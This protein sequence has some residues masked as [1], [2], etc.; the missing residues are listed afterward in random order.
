MTRQ[1]PAHPL[2]D[3][4]FYHPRYWPTWLGMVFL[5]LLRW[6]PHRW[7]RSIGQTIGRTLFQTNKKRCEIV[8]T[9]LSWALPGQNADERGNMLQQF[10][11]YSGQALLEYG[12]LWWSTTGQFSTQNRLEGGEWIQQAVD[13]GRRVMLITGH[14]LALDVGGMVVSQHFPMVTYA[15]RARN[16]LVQAMMAWGR[17]RYDVELLQ[18]ESG[19]RALLRSLKGGRI[20]Y[21]VIDEDMGPKLSV[22]A[23]FFGIAKATLSAPARVARMS[24]AIVAPCY[25]WF[26]EQQQRYRVQIGAPIEGFPSGDELEDGI[27]INQALESGILT[28]PEQYLWSQ[29]LFQSRPVGAPA[30]YTM[31]GYP[32]T[33]PRPREPWDESIHE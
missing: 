4:H 13:Q 29:R 24:D 30:P 23:P 18:R 1:R 19:I 27:K 20:L 21:Y 10:F 26:D 16:P 17:C 33:G 15:N 6:L 8:H 32:E 25:A 22:F 14:P 5:W 2:T 28:A 7:R 11:G 12:F 31:N 3:P 9:N